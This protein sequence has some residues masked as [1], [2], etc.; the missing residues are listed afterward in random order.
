MMS[1]FPLSKYAELVM[2]EAAFIFA[3]VG[4]LVSDVSPDVSVGFGNA[5]AAA[6]AAGFISISSIGED[7]TK[8]RSGGLDMLAQSEV[9]ALLSG[10][11]A[12][13]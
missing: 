6:T 13:Q 5:T 9:S 3:A 1:A 11:R 2:I 8:G 7:R 4:S 12:C 10:F